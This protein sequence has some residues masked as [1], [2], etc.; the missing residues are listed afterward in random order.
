[1]IRPGKSEKR[2]ESDKTR[3][4]LQSAGRVTT[5]GMSDNTR[6]KR[7]SDGNVT[8]SGE[9]KWQKAEKVTKYGKATK[10]GN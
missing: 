1:M 3:E 7:Q 8:K 2:R 10:A 5:C 4:T 6:E 9:D